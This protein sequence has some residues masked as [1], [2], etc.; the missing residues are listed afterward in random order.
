M[1]VDHAARAENVAWMAATGENLTRAAE[2]LGITV[3]A[4]EKWAQL[5]GMRA[6]LAALRSREVVVPGDRR[7]V[8]RRNAERRWAS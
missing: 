5:H 8:G 3:C 6:E 7:E 1:S 2:R 4:L